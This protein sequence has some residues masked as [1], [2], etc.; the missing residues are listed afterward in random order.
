MDRAGS[1]VG[2]ERF[3]YDVLDQRGH[4][5]WPV[6]TQP[7]VMTQTW[8]DLLFA[9]WPLDPAALRPLVPAAFEL[10]TFD[11]R[12]WIA[13]VPFTMSN[14]AP[15]FVP[16]LP[17]ISAFP[18]M[19]VRTYVTADGKPGVYF[20][21]LDAGSPVA[22]R[23]ARVLLNLPYYTADMSVDVTSRGV[24]YRSRRTFGGAPP[25][26]FR[27]SYRPDGPEA[28]PAPGS[29]EH[30][31]TER[32]CLYALNHRR[33]PYRLEIHHGP[34][35]LRPAL[36]AI[37]ENSMAAAAGVVLPGGAPLLHFSARQDM[38]GWMPERLA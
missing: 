21:S 15:R 23:A 24:T 17:G 33:Q 32:Y 25:A 37:E 14:V 1:P 4:R 12:A 38:V 18:E 13:V 5:P 30:F 36:A 11:G 7:W 34:W 19:N 10:D 26:A 16:A 8:G 27:A 2:G 22:V 6:P 3:R 31:L 29:L 35:M 9:H 28:P 20:F